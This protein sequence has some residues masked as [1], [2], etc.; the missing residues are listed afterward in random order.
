[1]NLNKESM[2]ISVLGCGWLGLELAKDLQKRQ[3]VV[4]GSTTTVSKLRTLQKE[5]ITPFLINLNRNNDDDIFVK[6]LKANVLIVNIPP[7]KSTTDNQ[8]YAESFLQ[9]VRLVKKSEI[10][11]V[12]FVSSTAVYDDVNGVVFEDS[13]IAT[14]IRAERLLA[15]EKLFSSISTSVNTIIRFG[16][17]CGNER[18][19]IT[20]LTGKSG[21]VGANIKTNMIYISDCI[22]IVI[23]LIGDDSSQVYNAVAPF[24]PTKVEFYNQMSLLFDL[25]PPIYIDKGEGQTG[26]EVDSSKLIN[27]IGYQ[28][29]FENPLTFPK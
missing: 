9:L 4:K 15:A 5:G 2:T 12:I 6:F 18:N 28:F 10:K 24:H 14:N 29:Q 11:Q 25:P 13:S 8:T 22:K 27:K 16:G 21:L 17:L 19:P 1:M 23:G 20:F 26:K 3:F 7:S